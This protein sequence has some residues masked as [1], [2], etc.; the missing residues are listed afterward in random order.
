MV[1][2]VNHGGLQ[3]DFKGRSR[4]VAAPIRSK[5]F[6][7]L[8]G[9]PSRTE[10]SSLRVT[11][12]VIPAMPEGPNTVAQLRSAA[13]PDFLGANREP[14]KGADWESKG[15]VAKAPKSGNIRCLA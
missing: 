13:H 11:D 5:K 14:L 8:F 12:E 3:A 6:N 15:K 10:D 9:V 7:L 2:Y 1:L 4:G